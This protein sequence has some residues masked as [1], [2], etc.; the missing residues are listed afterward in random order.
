MIKWMLKIFYFQQ[1]VVFFLN[2]AHWTC[3]RIKV[4]FPSQ[5]NSP[6]LLLQ[7]IRHYGQSKKFIQL[8]LPS[9][10]LP[11]VLFVSKALAEWEG[12]CVGF[13]LEKL[14]K[15]YKCKYWTNYSY[16]VSKTFLKCSISIWNWNTWNFLKFHK[17]GSIRKKA[18]TIKQK[19][20]KYLPQVY[21]A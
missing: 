20:E 16:L 18:T 10:N 2:R 8:L 19:R 9:P 17:D 5:S 3:N 21:W 4:F 1:Q 12:G 7:Q 11:I 15:D 14:P 6:S 13:C